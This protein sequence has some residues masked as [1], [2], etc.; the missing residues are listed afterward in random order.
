MNQDQLTDAAVR[1]AAGMKANPELGHADPRQIARASVKLA[2][3]I[4]DEVEKPE[5]LVQNV[6]LALHR[7]EGRGR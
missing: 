3:A 7:G 4:E 1:L 6:K 5:S 2:Q